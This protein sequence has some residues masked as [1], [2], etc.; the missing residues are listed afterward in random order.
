[1]QR[2]VEIDKTLCLVRFNYMYIVGPV[3]INDSYPFPVI[4]KTPLE[5]T[6]NA[7]NCSLDD[8]INYKILCKPVLLFIVN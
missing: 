4:A 8:K 2:R 6:V 1:M 7:T 5:I 3:C